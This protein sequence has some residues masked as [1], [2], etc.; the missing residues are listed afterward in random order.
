MLI[1][2]QTKVATVGDDTILP[3]HLEPATDAASM[4]LE[5]S[6]PDL[7]PTVVH[8]WHEGK[9][10][11]AD[12]NPSYKD[13]TTL[14]VEKLKQGDISL[15][16]SKVELSDNGTYRCYLPKLNTESFIRLSVGK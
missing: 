1:A 12:Q 2:S 8:V 4:T 7:K 16:L 15:K 13:R 14:F 10:A 5:W 11:L 3:C 9:V 6:R